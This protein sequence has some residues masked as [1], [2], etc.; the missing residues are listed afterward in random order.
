MKT[1]SNYI[2][3]FGE[4]LW[5]LL[6]TGKMP[7]GAPMNVA[8]HLKNICVDVAFISRVGTDALG[9][10]IKNFVSQK[11]CSI[12]WIQ[13]DSKYPT[14]IVNANVSNRNDVSYE[15]VHPAAWDFITVT[16]EILEVAKNA[17]AFVYGTLSCRSEQTRETLLNLLEDT[18]AL[19]IYD[20]NL[21]PPHYSKELILLLLQK[22]EIVKLNKDELLIVSAWLGPEELSIQSKLENLKTKFELQKVIVTLGGEGALLLD[23]SGF[24][25]SKVYKVEVKDTIGSGDAFLAG[26][27][28]NILLQKP[29]Q[30][31]LEYACAL[32]ALVAQH[33]G[34]NP[35]ILESEI[36]DL[37]NKS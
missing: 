8:L 37:I 32:G 36:F 27:I 25:S 34:A 1:Q 33:H 18:K 2:C 3:C 16:P 14:G 6:P 11:N 30:E 5:D 10:E 26:A 12:K 7:G 4:M 24:H 20:V 35:P 28:K 17:H 13:S 22:A 19:K 21:R 23:D 29:A 9:D 31:T 15:I